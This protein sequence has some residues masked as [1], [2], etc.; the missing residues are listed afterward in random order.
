MCQW[1]D[2]RW[3]SLVQLGSVGPRF[4]LRWRVGR[5]TTSSLPAPAG[6]G[7]EEVPF[8]D[9]IWVML[10]SLRPTLNYRRPVSSPS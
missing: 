10:V 2:T 6:A 4:L 1:V 7:S 5:A 3:T 8:L 9:W